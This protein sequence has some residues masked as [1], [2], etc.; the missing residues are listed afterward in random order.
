VSTRNFHA[1]GARKSETAIASHG[2]QVELTTSMFAVCQLCG[3]PTKT[4][5]KPGPTCTGSWI[6]KTIASNFGSKHYIHDNRKEECVINKEL[7]HSTAIP[8]L[9]LSKWQHSAHA[10]ILERDDND[11]DKDS[12]KA[13]TNSWYILVSIVRNSCTIHIHKEIN[14][15]VMSNDVC[16]VP[17]LLCSTLH[18]HT[19][20]KVI[21]SAKHGF[22]FNF[23]PTP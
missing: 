7:F 5:F 22:H 1:C 11:D 16:G 19:E 21:N 9:S 13:I 6:C 10:S 18:H 23:E 14:T 2:G 20:Y 12:S 17:P 3:K 4:E 15:N 8:L